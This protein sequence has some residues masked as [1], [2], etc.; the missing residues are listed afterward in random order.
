MSLILHCSL[1]TFDGKRDSTL[2][3]RIWL[4]LLEVY[5]AANKMKLFYGNNR[6]FVAKVIDLG[7]KVTL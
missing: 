5:V 1:S 6:Q 4:S 2:R 3:K 7:H